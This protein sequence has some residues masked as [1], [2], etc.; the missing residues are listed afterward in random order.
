DLDEVIARH[1]DPVLENLRL[2][3]EHH[4]F[5]M[6]FDDAIIDKET[7]KKG[8]REMS[9]AKQEVLFYC[10]LDHDTLQGH[11]ALLWTY[12]NMKVKEE[13]I[14]ITNIGYSL[15]NQHFATISK[16]IDWFK[17]AGYRA[18]KQLRS[19]FKQ[20]WAQRMEAAKARRGV[21][22]TEGQKKRFEGFNSTATT[23]SGLQTP[24][25]PG[26]PMTAGGFT[27]LE[28]AA[29]T[30]QGARAPGSAGGAA[31]TPRFGGYVTPNAMVPGTP[32]AKFVVNPGTARSR[33]P[34]SPAP[35][36]VPAT[37]G[38]AVPGT[39]GAGPGA[40]PW[41]APPAQAPRQSWGG[42]P[43]QPAPRQ[44]SRGG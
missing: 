11:G 32:N 41:G 10:L 18:S 28:T 26:N 38:G 35:S 44:S 13:F 42:P 16:L 7:C 25:G 30:P 5:N 31:G 14:E 6:G 15:W 43:A 37:P 3:Q 34:S 24:G 36:M 29:Q 39:P 33:A 27:G 21:D 17:E 12:G 8:L 23:T 20:S 9:R 2:M 22:V 4:R 19:E 40:Q 1:M